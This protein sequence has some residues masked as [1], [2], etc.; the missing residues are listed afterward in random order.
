MKKAILKTVMSAALATVMVGGANAGYISLD[1][2]EEGDDRAF[3]DEDTGIEWLKLSETA[4]MSINDVQAEL[5]AGG[6]Y[7]GW[8]LASAFEVE[9]ITEDITGYSAS[10]SLRNVSYAETTHMHEDFVDLF[11]WTNTVITGSG[12]NRNVHETSYGLYL[13]GEDVDMSG[14]RLYEDPKS[15]TTTL[16]FSNVYVGFENGYSIDYSSQYFAV[17]LVGDGGATLTTQQDMSL[18]ANNPNAATAVPEP[19][20]IALMAA[21]LLGLGAVR[22]RKQAKTGE[23]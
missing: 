7:E 20:G 4:G 16:Y 17:Y 2:Q 6:L 9:S 3:L 21:G 5:G 12:W 22:R 19:T 23:A 8:R 10:A 15:T 11:D 1:W 18:V 13:D 14:V